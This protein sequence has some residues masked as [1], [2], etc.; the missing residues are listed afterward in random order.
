MQGMIGQTTWDPICS[1]ACRHDNDDDIPRPLDEIYDLNRAVAKK[2]EHVFLSKGIP[3]VPSL[4]RY[5]APFV[6][7]SLNSIFPYREQ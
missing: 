1:R 6:E 3:V 4:G 5:F 2:M 7:T